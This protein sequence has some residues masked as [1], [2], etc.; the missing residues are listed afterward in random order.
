MTN[1]APAIRLIVST[2][3]FLRPC[4]SA[5]APST[6]PPMGRMTNPTA[7]T[8]RVDSSAAVSSPG[9]KNWPAKTGA[10]VA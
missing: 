2:S 10:R 5:Y 7:N 9:A 6:A 3:P 8:A 1:A 4:R